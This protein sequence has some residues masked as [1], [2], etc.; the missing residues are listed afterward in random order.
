MSYKEEVPS[1]VVYTTTSY[2][3][4]P[5]HQK[6]RNRLKLFPRF[7]KKKAAP[8]PLVVDHSVKI[9]QSGYGGVVYPSGYSNERHQISQQ[10]PG[11]V[12][13][14]FSHSSSSSSSS[15]ENPR[16][17]KLTYYESSYSPNVFNHEKYYCPPPPVS[18]Y[19]SNPIRSSR[20]QCHPIQT[21]RLRSH[22]QQYSEDSKLLNNGQQYTSYGTNSSGQTSINI[23]NNTNHINE[24]YTTTSNNNYQQ[25]QHQQQQQYQQQQQQQHQQYQQ[26]QHQQQHHS[27][28]TYNQPPPSNVDFIYPPGYLENQNSYE[29][30]EENN[31]FSTNHQQN[32]EPVY[33]MGMEQQNWNFSVHNISDPYSNNNY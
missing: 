32:Y 7:S 29:Y 26:Q 11:Q 24:E 19:S 14:S 27:S 21:D 33:P 9:T 17:D 25:Q 13:N 22:R 31:H 4:N 16:S 6:G 20:V 1:S 2:N 28:T 10:I 30:H 5:S 23:N 18:S 12:S 3:V 15:Y 8:Q